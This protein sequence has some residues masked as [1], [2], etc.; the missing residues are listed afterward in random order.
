MVNNMKQNRV[1]SG[2]YVVWFIVILLF[3]RISCPV[4][5]EAELV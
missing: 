2:V 4:M 5:H 1:K 3:F